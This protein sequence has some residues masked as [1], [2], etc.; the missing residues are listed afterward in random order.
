MKIEDYSFGSISIDGTSYDHDVIIDRGAVSKRKK[1]RSKRFRSQFG[2]TPLS[3]EEAIP[4][5]CKTLIVGTGAYG[6]LPVM[7]DVE[8][9]ARERHVQ[10][11]ALPTPNAIDCLNVLAGE[12]VNAVLHVTC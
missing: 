8:R 2:H 1:K 6:S 9:E 10:L 7:K 3:T 4:W 5:K 12:G 11:I